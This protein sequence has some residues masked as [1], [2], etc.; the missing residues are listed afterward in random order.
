MK[1]E[2]ALQESTTD[3]LQHPASLPLT[4]A[5]D[6]GIVR[7]TLELNLRKHPPH[8]AIKRIMQEEIGQQ[9]TD[10]SALR[11]ASCPLFQGA[12]CSLHGSS[13]PPRNIQ[14]YPRTVGVLCHSTVDQI[15]RNGSK[16]GMMVLTDASRH[17]W[18]EAR[19]PELTLIGFQDDAT[20][21]IL[22]AHFQLEPENT[23]GYLRAVHAMVTAHCVPLSDVGVSGALF[24]NIKSLRRF[25]VL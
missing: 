17:D 16:F 11:R 5:V 20:S 14:P 3:G 7:I 2:S 13:K 15:M 19:G 23:L 6:D 24:V 10:D 8:P 21:Q 25:V 1:I 9:R 4:P 12:V 18:L 22:S